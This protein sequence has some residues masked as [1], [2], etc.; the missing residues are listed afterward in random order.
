MMNTSSCTVMSG[1]AGG[2]SMAKDVLD[3]GYTRISSSMAFLEVQGVISM[4]VTI[5][6]M[7]VIIIILTIVICRVSYQVKLKRV[8]V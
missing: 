5:I 4:R 3:N 2:A 6:L 8:F 7:A 1:V